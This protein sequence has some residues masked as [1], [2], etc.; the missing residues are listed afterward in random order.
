MGLISRTSGR[1]E[2]TAVPGFHFALVPLLVAIPFGS[3]SMVAQ[4]VV[5]II[6]DIGHAK[7][8]FLDFEGMAGNWAFSSDQFVPGTDAP[9]T[10]EIDLSGFTSG[11]GVDFDVVGYD[12]VNDRPPAEVRG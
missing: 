1:V 12:D 9:V 6:R 3:V 8:V 11:M 4:F 10:L 2:V 5:T 7:T